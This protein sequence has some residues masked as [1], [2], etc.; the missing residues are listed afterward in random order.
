MH[1]SYWSFTPPPIISYS[2]LEMSILVIINDPPYGTETA[3][4]ALRMILAIHKKN[5][6]DQ[7]RLFL[8]ADAVTV[9][10][11]NQDTPKGFY[12]LERMLRGIMAKGT[13]VSLCGT[14]MNARGLEENGLID[15]CSRGSMDELASWVIEADRVLTF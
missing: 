9:A 13:T 8:M 4:N 11:K 15:G 5:E 6:A 7:I 2:D 1:T 10:L 14:C 12:N 3:Y